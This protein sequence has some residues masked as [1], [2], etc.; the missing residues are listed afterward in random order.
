M[1]VPND[2]TSG[3][4]PA[5]A[6]CSRL[7]FVITRLA[8]PAW[9][10]AAAIGIVAMLGARTTLIR[11]GIDRHLVARPAVYLSLTVVFTCAVWIVMFRH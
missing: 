2:P 9:I 10:T 11:T 1:A 8:V 5:C 6:P 3:A 4:S 7:G